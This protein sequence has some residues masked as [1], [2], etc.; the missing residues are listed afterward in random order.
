MVAETSTGAPPIPPHYLRAARFAER[1][2]VKM[3]AHEGP[4]LILVTQGRCEIDVLGKTLAGTPGT[5][6]ILPGRVEHNQ[7]NFGFVRT[8]YT[9]FM[10]FAGFD[11]TPRTLRADEWIDRWIRELCRMAERMPPGFEGPADHIIQALISR[12]TFI[13]AKADS[14]RHLHPALIKA[15]VL[16]ENEISNPPSLRAVARRAGLSVSHLSALFRANLHC[17]PIAYGLDHR[18][19]LAQTLLSDPH[20]SIKEIGAQCGFSNANYFCRIFRRHWKESPGAFRRRILHIQP[21]T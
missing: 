3:H 13:E 10:P 14:R 5:L 8:S 4:E 6:F 12:I 20:L 7:R 15:M 11:E 1:C 16:I 21:Q 19:R 2:Q 9:R 18:L 17:S